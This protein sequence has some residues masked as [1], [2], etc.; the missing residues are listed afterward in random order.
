MIYLLV[1]MGVVGF[2]FTTDG[3]QNIEVLVTPP[4]AQVVTLDADQGLQK[5]SWLASPEDPD[6]GVFRVALQDGRQCL[7]SR[8][9]Q[10]LAC[11]AGPVSGWS[12]KMTS[13]VQEAAEPPAPRIYHLQLE[14]GLECIGNRAYTALA[15]RWEAKSKPKVLDRIVALGGSE[16]D[17]QALRLYRVDFTDGTR[18]YLPHAKNSIQCN[19]AP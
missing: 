19:W 17:A 16:K 12:E 9:K 3:G 18:C 8:T 7:L 11:S 4:Q 5:A 1:M 14:D 6:L 2:L 10:A 15:C 13:F